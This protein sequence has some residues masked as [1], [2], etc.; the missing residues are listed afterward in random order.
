MTNIFKSNPRYAGLMNS[1][2]GLLLA[3]GTG[4]RL[5]PTTSAISK[6][7]IPIYDKPLIYYSLSTLMLAGCR[8][9]LIVCQARDLPNL[10]SLLG[11]GAKFGMRINYEVQREPLGIVHAVQLGSIWLGD[12]DF[13]LALGDNIFFGSHFTGFLNKMVA[14][15]RGAS[16]ALKQVADP[17]RFGVAWLGQS[18]KVERLQEKPTPSTS[19]LAVTGLYYFDRTATSRV[20]DQVPSARGELEILDLLETYRAEGN[21]GAHALPRGTVW[22]DTGTVNS[23]LAASNFVK[24]FQ[25][26]TNQLIGS[27]EEIAW[28][29]GW[30]S[31]TQLV[32]LA[33]SYSNEY[34][35]KLLKLASLG[36]PD[37]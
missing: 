15:S 5:S 11:E 19:N 14:S 17:E 36:Q 3:G 8:E 27:P 28:G 31:A 7:F 20:V 25:E 22:Q 23:L 33:S 12:S 29:R 30:I 9:V 26:L 1:V 37:Q 34:G 24:S 6:H 4:T 21:L 16:I 18:G 2:K 13:F 35:S 10:K 32:D